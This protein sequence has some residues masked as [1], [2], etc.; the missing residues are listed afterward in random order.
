MMTDNMSKI[1]TALNNIHEMGELRTVGQLLKER[2][3]QLGRNNK[4]S[5]RVNEWVKV[6]RKSGG[7]LRG[8]IIKK[9]RTRAEVQ[10]HIS[11]DIYNVPFSLIERD[12]D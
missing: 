9:N 1:F 6:A 8:R 5:L 3:R 2:Q 4:S 10:T 7:W 11:G 12:D